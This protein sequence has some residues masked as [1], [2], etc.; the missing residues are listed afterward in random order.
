MQEML[1][2]LAPILTVAI[3]LWS[4]NILLAL[5]A[6]LCYL[7]VLENGILFLMPLADHL[8]SGVT[9]NGTTLMTLIPLG[10]ML[11][12]IRKGGG[13]KAFSLWSKK[14]VKDKKQAGLLV[15][16]VSA[17]LSVANDL[18]SNVTTGQIVRPIITQKRVSRHKSAFITA[19]TAPNV[20]SFLPF[21]TYY[22]FCVGMLGSLLPET[23]NA[24]AFFFKGI[25]LSFY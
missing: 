25:P 13:F 5:F 22:L 15:F 2:I 10:I 6:G 3:A 23:E 24:T 19:S 20:A 9:S 16:L 18:L 8:I 7:S 12:F 21:Q 11:W 1:P 14:K 4:K 17:I